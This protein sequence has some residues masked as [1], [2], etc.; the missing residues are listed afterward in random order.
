M[1]RVNGGLGDGE[2]GSGVAA[3]VTHDGLGGEY[4]VEH[5]MSEARAITAHC[6]EISACQ[7]TDDVSRQALA[8]DEP[9]KIAHREAEGY[10]LA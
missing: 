10:P 1:V 9:V 2:D 5:L 8:V 3:A 4:I 7:P 6:Q